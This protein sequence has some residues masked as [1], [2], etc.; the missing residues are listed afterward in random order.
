MA[1]TSLD[2]VRTLAAISPCSLNR[3][4]LSDSKGFVPRIM[5]R[6]ATLT[7]PAKETEPHHGGRGPTEPPKVGFGG[8]DWKN[9]PPGRRGPH[10]RLKR[11]RV[12]VLLALISVFTVFIGLTSAY[13]VRQGGGKLDTTTGTF[14]RDWKPMVVPRILWLNTA[15]L[16]LSSFTIEFARRQ[17]FR[18]PQVTEEWLGMGTPTR[19]ASL[20]WL[21]ITLL[22][23]FGFLA[24]QYAAWRQ[25]N[26]AGI[27]LSTGPSSSFF[28]ILTGAHAVHL[29]VGLVVLMWA[30][31]ASVLSRSL[32][33]R[34]IATDFGAWY[35]HA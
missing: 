4:I 13:V 22:L 9:N 35:W 33:S 25:L 7:P 30:A 3:R 21:G 31:V 8:D 18:E 26:D 17:V 23:G 6:P 19:R 5:S 32:E 11:F 34:Q 16:L 2:R 14:V 28:F 12:G 15:L 1:R 29:L 10:E 24:G 20:P 27:F